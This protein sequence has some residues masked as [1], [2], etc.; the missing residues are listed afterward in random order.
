MLWSS[1][2]CIPF[3]RILRLCPIWFYAF[4]LYIHIHT[5]F[6]LF[7]SPQLLFLF[8]LVLCFRLIS[9][10]HD[11]NAQ[12]QCFFLGTTFCLLIVGENEYFT[13]ALHMNSQ[14]I[15]ELHAQF[16]MDIRWL[17]QTLSIV[18]FLLCFSLYLMVF[19]AIRK[20]SVFGCF[21]YCCVIAVVSYLF[22]AWMQIILFLRWQHRCHSFE[23]FLAPPFFTFREAEIIW[24][25]LNFL[26]KKERS[27]TH[28]H[29]HVRLNMKN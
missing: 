16:R 2:I 18:P 3:V 7:V 17:G 12:Q 6:F 24:T 26:N 29:T 14:T 20:P 9:L 10:Q 1:S 4:V 28:T 15:I 27:H 5:Y 25:V 19:A 8:S 11:R 13:H 22:Q 21:C 23:F